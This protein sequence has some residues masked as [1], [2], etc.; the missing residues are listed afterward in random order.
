MVQ[1]FV[2]EYKDD[3]H[4]YLYIL[5]VLMFYGFSIV[6]L[7][8]KYIKREREGHRKLSHSLP[9]CSFTSHKLRVEHEEDSCLEKWRKLNR[10]KLFIPVVYI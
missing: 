1:L 3:G 8:V 7:M 9:T 10:V 2:Q 6:V 5:F 4:A